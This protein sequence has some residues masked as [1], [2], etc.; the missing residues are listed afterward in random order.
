MMESKHSLCRSYRATKRIALLA[1]FILVN[2]LGYGQAETQNPVSPFWKLKG[3]SGSN[4]N[5]NFIGTT[6]NVSLHIRTRNLER[7]RLDSL[8]KIGI[9]TAVP[10][11]RLDIAGDL[12]LREK[13]L[14]MSN[15]FNNNIAVDTNSFFRLTG[16]A[17]IRVTGIA[18]GYDGKIVTLFNSTGNNMT[19]Y[20][21]NTNSIDTNRIITGIGDANL[22][23]TSSATF[24][25]SELTDRWVLIGT[26]KAAATTASTSWDIIGNSG[27]ISNTNFIGTIDNR[28]LSFRTNNTP[29]MRLDSLGRL[30]INTLTPLHKL[31][32]IN[33]SPSGGT[34]NP[35]A[36]L[37]MDDFEDSYIHM[38]NGTGFESGIQFGHPNTSIDGSLT[39]DENQGMQLST[40]GD[41]PRIA[42]TPAGSVGINTTAP[43]SKLDVAGDLS[44]RQDTLALVNGINNN[45]NTSTKKYSFYIL[46]GP[47]A[48]YSISGFAGFNNGRIITLFNRTAFNLSLLD[49]NAGSATGAQIITGGGA[50]TIADSGTVT[51]QYSSADS[52]WV[53]TSF[54]NGNLSANAAAWS[55]TG[56]AGTSAS[57]NFLG[58]TD[59]VD[60]S[61]RVGNQR[62]GLINQ[63]AWNTLF[64]YQAALGNT[65]TH[66]TAIGYN[67]QR[68]VTG[69]LYNTGLGAFTLW[70]NVNGIRNT[71]IGTAALYWTTGSDNTA[72]GC[73]SINQNTS[74]VRNTAVGSNAMRQ[75]TTGSYNVAMGDSALMQNVLGRSNVAI[76]V[77]AL[78]SNTAQSNLVAVGDSAMYFNTT[79]TENTALGSKALLLNTSGRSNIAV[80]LRALSNNISGNYNT[81]MG[82]GALNDNQTGNFNTAIGTNALNSSL[83]SNNIAIG[84]A[85][86]SNYTQSNSIAI[87]DSA[88]FTNVSTA[89]SLAIGYRAGKNNTTGFRNFFIGDQAGYYNTTGNY[90]MFIGNSAGYSNTTGYANYFIGENSGRTNTT[91]QL[92]LCIGGSSATSNTT[93]SFNYVFGDF[94]LSLN[95]TSSYNSVW[96]R[97]TFASHNV[98]DNNMV[99]G[100]EAMNANGTGSYN[101]VFGNE[102][103]RFAAVANRMVAFGHQ[104]LYYQQTVTDPNLAI[105]AFAGYNTTTGNSNIFIGDSVGYNN[106]LGSGNTVIGY[107][108]YKNN[109]TG[110][111]NVAIGN[112]ALFRNNTFNNLVAIGDSA[113]M[114]NGLGATLPEATQNTAVGSKALQ[115][116][117]R[118]YNVTATG[119]QA[120]INNTTGNSNSAFGALTLFNNTDGINNTGLGY[121]ALYNTTTG[122]HNTAVGRDALAANVSGE[123]NTAVGLQALYAATG[124]FNVGIGNNANVNVTTG[125]TNTAIG[126]AAGASSGALANTSALGY[127]ASATSSNYVRIG[128]T[129]V[130]SIFGN[131][132]FNTSD[133]RFKT[134]VQQNVPGLNFIT[135]LRP[136]TYHFEKQK[137]SL[138]TGER[139]DD[140]YVAE[141]KR[142]DALGKRS[143]GFIAQEVQRVADSLGYD[144]D[145]LY[146]PQPGNEHDTYGLSYQQFVV[147]LIKAVQEQQLIIEELKRRINILEKN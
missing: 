62:S 97:Y 127:N 115:K 41:V 20:E 7:M 143:T 54:S 34:T 109:F 103:A 94:G 121:G 16:S 93:G 126:Y 58:T 107:H 116:N 66:N 89:G 18:G 77:T 11:T 43:Q 72:V 128:N 147:P 111:S 39:Y 60:L 15:G 118:G 42:I 82:I 52:K 29:R 9:A 130:T 14:T 98:G 100:W 88:L 3:N 74:G 65:G 76:G 5:T 124:S 106:T 141:L 1:I 47:T 125:G 13:T 37:A 78:K 64:G 73:E 2:L 123:S 69:G 134:D 61:F 31:H 129:A 132:A 10:N 38:L 25:Y 108:A 80:G 142:Q 23:A 40:G 32:I 139:Q 30:G 110:Y 105:G 6:D 117:T 119:F 8:G 135:K 46:R 140:F 51:L 91:G 145:G 131:V 79:G 83:G 92:N 22:G 45:V 4:S 81:V 28:S 26:N 146:I 133:G 19:I 96:G 120:L 48:A 67:C 49:L 56:N 122:D 114:N 136:I 75:N 101:T 55:V 57:A 137:Y 44:L 144:F 21:Q 112:H 85:A 50:L 138:H 24:I 12:A 95:Q 86:S 27:T 59:A 70:T 71:G 63:N 104:A 17:S 90:G 99:F 68:N 36:T 53:V 35:I 84:T 113:L 33:D 102:V 87:G